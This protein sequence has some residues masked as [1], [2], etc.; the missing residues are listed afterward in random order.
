[1]S[2]KVMYTIAAIVVLAVLVTVLDVAC[3]MALDMRLAEVPRRAAIAVGLLSSPLK[4]T[5][6]APAPVKAT[7]PPEPVEATPTPI[8][9]TPTPKPVPA[10]STP[11]PPTPT[12]V[13]P[14]P[15]PPTATRVLPTP[16]CPNPRARLTYPT[17]GA[18]LKGVVKMK[19][20]ANIEKFGWYRF[21][22]RGK[23]ASV[24][25]FLQR[26]EKPVADGVLGLWDTS[27]LPAD[28]Y[29]FRLTVVNVG[30]LSYAEPCE[31]E[32]TILGSTPKPK[33]PPATPTPPTETTIPPEEAYRRQVCKITER[34]ALNAVRLAGL[35]GARNAQGYRQK[36]EELR[37]EL[38]KSFSIA[39][40]VSQPDPLTQG[41]AAYVSSYQEWVESTGEMLRTL[42]PPASYQDAHQE[43]V[44]ASQQC[45]HMVALL[46]AVVDELDATHK[47]IRNDWSAQ[48]TKEFE[49]VTP[50]TFSLIIYDEEVSEAN[51]EKLRQAEDKLRQAAVEMYTAGLVFFSTPIC[52]RK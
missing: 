9:P 42:E 37:E 26:F 39:A 41:V 48:A 50:G 10:T 18:G 32:V 46:P 22:F 29:V 17:V 2:D 12:P 27:G 3:M 43:L 11:I 5:A 47:S 38:I 36:P 31:V 35:L 21:E 8:P 16:D 25:S 33:P 7:S 34:Y 49:N 13:P 15:I 28:A 20:S 14:T 51:T 6:M 30:G 1:M 4:P 23:G 52:D 40:R 44:Q 45:D 19:G 24:W